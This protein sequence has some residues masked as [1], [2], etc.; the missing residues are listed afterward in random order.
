M[1]I[2]WYNVFMV[3][4]EIG[5]N[6]FVA[7]YSIEQSIYIIFIQSGLKNKKAAFNN[8]KHYPVWNSYSENVRERETERERE[9]ERERDYIVMM[10]CILIW[11]FCLC[12]CVDG[13]MSS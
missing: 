7:I 1:E 5:L 13:K 6:Y 4:Y 3:P 10:L 9:R 11:L 12:V 2:V 8:L